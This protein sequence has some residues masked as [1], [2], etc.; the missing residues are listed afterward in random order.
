LLCCDGVCTDE[1]RAPGA[2]CDDQEQCCS[3]Y[4]QFV[5]PDE[6]ACAPTCQGNHCLLDRDCCR[7]FRCTEVAAAG[8]R[9]CGGCV[10]VAGAPCEAD[11]DCCFSDCTA[12]AGAPRK[13]CG[14]LP[15][16]PCA[17]SANCRSCNLGG[18][19]T[20]TVNGTPSEIC[21]AGIC[22]CPDDYEC[23]S[24][25]DCPEGTFCVFAIE[26]GDLVGECRSLEP[27]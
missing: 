16:G 15:G 4:C 24:N 26:G 25:A 20:V 3:N 21:Q 19:C 12:V 6:A 9:F 10:D 18:D 17:R 13:G 5:R 27:G 7:G 1:L 22:G 8:E 14:S 2:T 23:C 11:A